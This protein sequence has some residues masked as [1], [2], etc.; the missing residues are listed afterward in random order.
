MIV[1]FGQEIDNNACGNQCRRV[2][3]TMGWV[4]GSMD[5]STGEWQRWHKRNWATTDHME[6]RMYLS[7]LCPVWYV[8]V[9]VQCCDSCFE[10]KA[11]C[12]AL[13]SSEV[14]F[15]PCLC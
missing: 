7:D 1:Q 11:R 4:L 5:D 15:T 3:V 10:G 9:G 8:F 13:L 6:D 2:V 14:N 12:S